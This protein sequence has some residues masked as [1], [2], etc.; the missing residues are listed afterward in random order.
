MKEKIVEEWIKRA[1]HDWAAAKLLYAQGEY[2]DTVLFHIHQAIEKY[3]KAYLQHEGWNLKK[4]HDIEMLLTETFQYNHIFE[5]YLD[6]GRKITG[7]YIETRY[8]PG[9]LSQYCRT[10]IKD[11]LRT[12]HEIITLITEFILT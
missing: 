10:E 6:F 2:F 5:K 3:L 4:T 7:Y 8:P 11:M 9:P 1:D 12:A